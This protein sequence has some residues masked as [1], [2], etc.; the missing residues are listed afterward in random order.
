MDCGK[1]SVAEP[2]PLHEVQSTNPAGTGIDRDHGMRTS[3]RPPGNSRR[4]PLRADHASGCPG[5]GLSDKRR[6]NR[7]DW[8]RSVGLVREK[9]AGPLWLEPGE[10]SFT[11][12][13][14]G[15]VPFAWPAEYQDPSRTPLKRD[16]TTADRI[17]ELDVPEPRP[18]SP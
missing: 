5:H 4:D 1:A 16:W 7:R 18:S 8:L 13:S 10:Y 9:A 12:E 3:T 15:S 11:L 6:S 14:N 2:E 17:L